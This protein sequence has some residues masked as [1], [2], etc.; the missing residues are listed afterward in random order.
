MKFILSCFRWCRKVGCLVIRSI[1][2]MCFCC[3]SLYGFVL[4][5]CVR[6]SGLVLICVFLLVVILRSLVVLRL[7]CWKWVLILLVILVICGWCWFVIM[8]RCWFIVVCC[9]CWNFMWFLVDVFVRCIIGIFILLCLVLWR[10]GSISGCVICL[11]ILFIWLIFMGI[12][13]MVI[14]VIIWVVCSCCF[15]FIWWIFR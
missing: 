1:L 9:C 5:I 4:I 12:F 10:V 15:L 6:G 13:L 2:L 11:I 7:F 8:S 3:V 14:V